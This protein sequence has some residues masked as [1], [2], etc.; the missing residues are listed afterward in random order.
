[1]YTQIKRVDKSSPLN[2]YQ[3]NKRL[4]WQVQ[5]VSNELY[6]EHYKPTEYNKDY[7]ILTTEQ[8]IPPWLEGFTSGK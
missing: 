2:E 6:D 7:S 3:D 5:N 8:Y 1:M 4:W